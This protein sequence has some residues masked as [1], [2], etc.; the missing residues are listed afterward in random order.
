MLREQQQIV[1]LGEQFGLELETAEVVQTLSE[2][3][4]SA[5]LPAYDG[6]IAGDDPATQQV[7]ADAVS[8][9]LRAVI[10][11]G[12]GIDNVDLNAIDNFA[13]KFANTPGMFSNEVADL[14]IGYLICLAR[15]IVTVDREVRKGNWIK[16]PG[17]SLAGKTAAVVGLGNIGRAVVK[18]LHV[19]GVNTIGFDPYVTELK[20]SPEGAS[21]QIAVW[22]NQ[23]EYVDF[24]F[25]CCA[26]TESNHHLINTTILSKLP[27]HAQIINVSRGPLIDET[28]LINAL[29]SQSIAGAALDVFESEPL[30]GHSPLIDMSNVVLGSHNASNTREAVRKTNQ[31]AVELLAGFLKEED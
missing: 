31:K 28:A 19:M 22:P 27:Q 3:E 7:L 16:P 24:V 11:W 5:M 1:E 25:L 23:V 29:Q 18:R 26:L 8:G 12:I 15:Q 2:S 13:I 21:S 6:W 9:K 20:D 30:P 4:L 14:A 10:K 17:I